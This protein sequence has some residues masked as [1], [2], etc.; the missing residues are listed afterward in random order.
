MSAE[1]T[2]SAAIMSCH[3]CN[4]AMSAI[5]PWLQSAP[6]RPDLARARTRPG[7]GPDPALTRTGPRG[8]VR[9]ARPGPPTVVTAL[10]LERSSPKPLERSPLWS[11]PH[12]NLLSDPHRIPPWSDP[13]W[14]DPP[15]GAISIY[16]SISLVSVA[17]SAQLWGRARATFAP[18]GP[19]TAA[20][21]A[22][23]NWGGVNKGQ[24]AKGKGGTGW[25]RQVRPATSG[26]AEWYSLPLP[27]ALVRV[28]T[29]ST[30][31]RIEF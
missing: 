11:D 7:P 27:L 18:K 22:Q 3:V 24:G 30:R 15:F 8:T 2:M 31:T 17:V 23:M 21:T 10:P 5:V 14:S 6:L 25:A 28:R 4:R 12:R 13:L 29:R 20:A 1:K 16:I 9:P 19:A 26:V